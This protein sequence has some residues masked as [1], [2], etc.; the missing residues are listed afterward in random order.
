MVEKC[1]Q[2]VESD[3]DAVLRRFAADRM[4]KFQDFANLKSAIAPTKGVIE[5]LQVQ[6]H[7]Q[8]IDCRK[9]SR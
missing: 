8:N 2:L 4:I 1:N 6:C 5:S 7:P 9:A 3:N